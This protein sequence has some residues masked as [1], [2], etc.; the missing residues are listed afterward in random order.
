MSIF[1]EVISRKKEQ[2]EILRQEDKQHLQQNSSIALSGSMED[3]PTYFHSKEEKVDLTKWQQDL[4]DT[5]DELRHNLLSEIFTDK[6]WKPELIQTV[7]DKGRPVTLQIKPLINS[8]GCS[9]LMSVVKRYLNRNVMMSNLSE[10][11]ILRMLRRLKTDIVINLGS[12]Y[13]TFEIDP[14]NLPIIVRMIMDSVEPTLYRS[15]ENGE[16]KYLNTINKRVETFSSLP[17][18]QNN[19]KNGIMGVFA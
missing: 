19:K 2:Q 14:V 5:I 17:S 1:S 4:E 7:D 18:N 9:M 11:T 10:E 16:R 8:Y 15:Y 13:Q 6:G 3:D 12:Q